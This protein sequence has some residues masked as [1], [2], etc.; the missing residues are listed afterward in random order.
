MPRSTSILGSRL[1]ET[2]GSRQSTRP[3]P[4]ARKRGKDASIEVILL[5]ALASASGCNAA[6]W[7]SHE[8]RA[9]RIGDR[10][11]QDPIDLGLG[12]DIEPPARYPVDRLQLI[13]MTRAPQRRGN[14]LVE[15]P[16]DRHLNDALAETVL[17][18][19]IEP[20]HGGQILRKPGLEELRVTASQIVAIENGIWPHAS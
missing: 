14:T 5:L 4:I 12:G 2:A 17:G 1:G 8:L 9:N 16:T 15:H 19:P 13:G 11:L 3:N 18:E 6:R 10:L 7:R 20:L